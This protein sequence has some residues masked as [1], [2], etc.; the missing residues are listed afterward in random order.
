M[1][2][3]RATL[4]ALLR[5]EAK[6]NSYKFA[7]VRALNDLALTYPVP[8]G[9]DVVVPLRMVAERWLVA[10]WPFVGPAPIYQ[11]A[12]AVRDG[13]R[14]IQDVS[15]RASLT[16]LRAQWEAF[17]GLPGT[18]ADGAL[19][20]ADYQVNR[21]RLPTDLQAAVDRCVADIARAVQQPVRYAG[22]G[23]HRVFGPPAPAGT[24]P[25]H[26]LPGTGPLERAFTVPAF[27]WA[28]LVEL[29]LWV[30]ALCLH[31]WSLYVERV[32]QSP[33]VTRGEVFTRLTGAPAGRVPLT[34]ER[35]QVELLMLEGAVFHCPWTRVSL[36]RESFDLDH[37]IPL[38]AHPIN[39]L[40]NLLPCD[41]QHNR[42]V[43]RARVPDAAKLAEA[44]G[45]IESTYG[46]YA[47][48]AVTGVVLQRDVEARF[49]VG[50]APQPLAGAVVRLADHL[51]QA[52]NLPRY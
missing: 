1:A 32:A 34:W 2:D 43:K 39:E 23:A 36:T 15:F 17:T 50:L 47:G 22:G 14:L 16:A 9:T 37:L 52:R 25:G 31:E 12:R 26:R 13:G 29:S 42:H 48:H 28:A 46:L 7:L 8:P 5:H 20:L 49:G 21:G 45:T 30:E 44:V 51:A 33:A 10:Y 24:L 11:G 19:L 35:H 41:R 6:S 3:G 40:W 18:D 27:V 38:A 4:A